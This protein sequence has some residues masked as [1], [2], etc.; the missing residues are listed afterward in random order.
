MTNSKKVDSC[1]ELFKT[2]EILPFCSQYIFSLLLYVVNNKHR[3]TKNFED[4][5]TTI[6]LLIIFIY[7]LLI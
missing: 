4:I 3:F 5:N 2:M 1:R 7:P 6:D